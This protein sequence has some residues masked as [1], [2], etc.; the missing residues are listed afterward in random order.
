MAFGMNVVA[1]DVVMTPDRAAAIGCEFGG[2][3]AAALLALAARCDAFSVHLPGGAETKKMFGKEFFGA[4]KPGAYF[5][6]TSRA[7]VVDQAALADAV[8]S[9][10]VRAG[11]DVYDGE[12]AEPET[13]WSC[14]LTKVPGIYTTHHCGASTDQAQNAVAM[15]VVRIVKVYRESGRVENAVIC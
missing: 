12:P 13:K 9:K 10:G 5:I 15:E 11:L 1:W 4:I 3:D 2:T 14:D 6:N 7:S 8:A